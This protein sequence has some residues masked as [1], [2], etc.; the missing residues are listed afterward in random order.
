LSFKGKIKMT[1]LES[2]AIDAESE[3]ER[4]SYWI[5]EYIRDV[6]RRGIVIGLSGGIDSS[7]TAALCAKALGPD[8]V[9][10]VLMPEINSAQE[11]LDLAR[12]LVD[13]LGI[14]N[15]TEEI[16]GILKEVGCYTRLHNTIRTVIPEYSDDSK[17]KIVLPPV[18]SGQRYQL[19]SLVV[20]LPNGMQHR[21]LLPLDAY[22][23]IVAAMNFKQ[24]VR[25]MMEYYHADRL[26]YAVAGTPNWLEYDQGFFVKNGDG[27][28]D[29]KPI[30]H[31]Y[32][33]QVFKLGEYLQLPEPILK[34]QPTTDTY[35]LE[36]S[37]EEFF[38]GI[39]YQ[40]MDMA[41][42]ALD[43]SVTAAAAGIELGLS[44]DEVNHLY[45][46]IKSRRRAAKFLKMPPR[47]MDVK[48]EDA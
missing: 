9:L 11:S 4:I 44:E 30:A 22:L 43:H 46:L 29:L 25:K 31:L 24:R 16:T 1:L 39:P 17:F 12:I 14:Q 8:K 45:N 47:M 10:G 23:N 6:K 26:N 21:I 38:F 40:Q 35:S 19:F 34:R 3:V 33:S 18:K 41:A 28:A 42:Y 48:E 32:K 20:Q 5:Y 15:V 2:I 36:Q 7:V 37:Q 27:A 13:Q